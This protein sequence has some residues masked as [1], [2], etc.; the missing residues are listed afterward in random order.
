MSKL[1][2]F[3][4]G[5]SNR[6]S[7]EFHDLLRVWNITAVADVRSTPWSRR[8]PQFNRDVLKQELESSN[9][10]YRFMGKSLGGRPSRPELYSDETAD[11]EKMAMEPQFE[12][13]LSRVAVAGRKHRLALLCSEH[14][15]IDCHRCL[16]VGRQLSKKS[17]VMHHIVSATEMQTQEDIEARILRNIGEDQVDFL[18]PRGNAISHAYQEWSRRVAYSI[19]PQRS[20]TLEAEQFEWE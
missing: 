7:C 4:I 18:S 3:T 13:A 16:L 2:V 19:P 1:V 20:H 10:V 11:Y 17:I 9:I 14:D 8:N 15:P 6:S 5:H 12:A